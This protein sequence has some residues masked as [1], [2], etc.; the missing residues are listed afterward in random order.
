MKQL[1]KNL[2]NFLDPPLYTQLLYNWNMK[3]IFT[4]SIICFA[5]IANFEFSIPA[6][7]LPFNVNFG[8]TSI[9]YFSYTIE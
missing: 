3:N 1:K 9:V 4:K 8:Y 2:K 7:T 6:R 5:T